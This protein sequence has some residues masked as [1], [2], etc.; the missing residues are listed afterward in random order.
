MNDPYLKFVSSEWGQKLTR[1]VG[2]P[3]P[4]R[5]A[6]WQAGQTHPVDGTLL[7][8]GDALAL[9]ASAYAGELATEVLSWQADALPLQPW[10]PASGQLL[11]AVLFDA[12]GIR[13]SHELKR[14]Y[15]CFQP[16]L[17]H[18]APNAR[19]VLLGRPPQALEAI[20]AQV[21]QRALEGFTRSLA[22]ELRQGA[23]AQLLYVAEQAQVHLEAALRFFLSAKSAYINGQVLS[24]RASTG[25]ATVADWQRPLAGR[26]ALVTGAARGIGAAIAETLAR[27]GASVVLVDLPATQ[28][29]LNGL[30]LRL[31]GSSLALDITAADAPARLIDALP[32]GVDILVH[33]AGITR[34][35]TVANMA[36]ELWD[37]VIAVN[38]DAPRL[39]T[40]AL[41]AAG[42][43]RDDA[44]VVL[45]SSVS[46]IGGNRGQANYAA[47]KA[48]LVG[49]AE[50]LAPILAERGIGI[51]AVA[52][53]FIE[54]HMTEHMPF[55][56][57]ETGRRM[58]VL[59][60]AGQ[61]QDV[62]EAVAWLAQPVGG[63][64]NGQV[65]RVCG[66][67]YLGA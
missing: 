37:P 49:L 14:L 26:K 57:R 36:A 8:A 29:E 32:E 17:R 9:A 48:G 19:L 2:L 18:L 51:A 40:E 31:G 13:Q 1:A 6:R 59:G 50:A 44:R 61:P 53:G 47:S 12:S 45:L 34:D 11:K 55:A 67:S 41:F 28:A 62:A 24:L 21:S 54:T 56:L 39:L 20:E 65:L 4:W 23:T 3:Q 52:P 64:L 25:A 58:N 7:L 10:N 5:L 60:Q 22:K 35:K 33:N 27:D 38:L 16:L 66:Q 30:A 43:L 42:S 15:E 46:A 63:A